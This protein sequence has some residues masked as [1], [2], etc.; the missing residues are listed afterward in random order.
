MHVYSEIDRG[1]AFRIYLPLRAEEV[2]AT[3]GNQLAV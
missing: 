3:R 1:T 2:E